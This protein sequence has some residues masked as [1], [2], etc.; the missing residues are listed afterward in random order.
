M[1][2]MDG[3]G[4]V[5]EADGGLDELFQIDRVGIFAGAAGDLQH[6][7][8][9]FLL[10]GLDDG[11]DEFHVV[12]VESAE[13]VFAFEGLGEQIF[14][15]CQRHNLLVFARMIPRPAADCRTAFTKGT[16]NYH[17]P[18]RIT[19]VKF[20]LNGSRF[21]TVKL[22]TFDWANHNATVKQS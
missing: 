17:Q 11:L 15:V 5:R 3:D 18:G 13:G 9:F 12:D 10:A 2:E 16:I 1:V 22:I 4:D 7:R 21:R 19:P 20:I 6:D 8:G 14:G